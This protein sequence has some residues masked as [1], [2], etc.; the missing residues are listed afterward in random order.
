MA[1]PLSIGRVR[2]HRGNAGELTVI[3]ASGRAERWEGLDRFLLDRG[4]GVEPIAFEVEGA[5]AYRDRLILKLKGVDDPGTAAGLKG[6]TVWVAGDAVPALPEGE[7]YL[8]RLIGM[9][10]REDGQALGTVADIHEAG[11]THVMV[12]KTESGGELLIPLVQAMVKEVEETGSSI[13]VVLPPGLK[14]LE[15]DKLP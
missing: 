1:V 9:T 13:H 11:G 2:G 10:V 14:E 15:E 12:V 4:S 8:D 3:I 7:Y 6:S 5:R